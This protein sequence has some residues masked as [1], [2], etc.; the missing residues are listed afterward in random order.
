MCSSLLLF[1]ALFGQIAGEAAPASPSNPSLNGDSIPYRASIQA[2]YDNRV[3]AQVEGLLVT[4]N[5]TEGSQVTEGQVIGL[6]D[7]RTAQAA[8]DVAGIAFHA[9]DERA[10]DTV[11]ERYA[12][13]AAAVAK[14]DYEMG[15][16]ANLG[17]KQNISIIEMEKKKLDEERATLQIEK[18]QKDRR[19]ARLDADTKLAELDAN[20]IALERRTIVTPFAG[21]VQTVLLHE[22]EWANP[23]DPILRLIQFDVMWV[24]T[25]VLAQDYDPA[26][27]MGKPVTV[28]VS[29]AR[30]QQAQVKG[31]VIYVDQSRIFSSTNPGQ[32]RVRAE[33]KNQRVGNFW[34]VHPGPAQMVIHVGQPAVESAAVAPAATVEQR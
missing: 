22:S 23:G 11:E 30:G 26:D 31:R 5:V 12:S 7:D 33:I 29:L 28:T 34:L 19:L 32:Y 10:K 4:L 18:A 9:A 14:K 21:E 2:R 1:V 24:E 3:F 16:Q 17:G 6:I 20:K 15:L 25:P 13:K 8:V 27:L